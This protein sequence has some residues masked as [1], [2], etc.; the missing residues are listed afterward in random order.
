[1]IFRHV[2]FNFQF[3]SLHQSQNRLPC[4]YDLP[5]LRVLSG[6]DAQNADHEEIVAACRMGILLLAAHNAGAL[7]HPDEGEAALEA[8]CNEDGTRYALRDAEGKTL[9]EGT[10]WSVLAARLETAFAD[11]HA[12][13]NSIPMIIWP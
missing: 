5:C 2:Y 3:I 13:G 10:D 9:D 12:E 8:S 1:M 6:E 7:L 11:A 4:R